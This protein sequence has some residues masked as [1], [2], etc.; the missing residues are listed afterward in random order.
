MT[1]GRGGAPCVTLPSDESVI[2]TSD[3]VTDRRRALRLC[4]TGFNGHRC[5]HL[6]ECGQE[7]ERLGILFGV[8]GGVD[9]GR[10]VS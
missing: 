1:A 7:A 10:T 3:E 4:H 2:W 5:P 8:W 6:T 9:R